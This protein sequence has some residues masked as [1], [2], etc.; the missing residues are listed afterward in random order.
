MVVF[1][2]GDRELNKGDYVNVRITDATA[3]TLIG[4]M[5]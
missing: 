5:V 4:E 3:A 2:K 1:P